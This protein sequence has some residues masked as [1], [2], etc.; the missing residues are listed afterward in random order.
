MVILFLLKYND[1]QF[2]CKI[3]NKSPRKS[4]KKKENRTKKNIPNDFIKLIKKLGLQVKDARLLYETKIDWDSI[5]SE[6]KIY[7]T[8][9]GCDY[10]TQIDSEELTDH[11]MNVH[12]C[13]KYE[14]SDPDCSYIGHS[15]VN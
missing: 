3:D 15:K 4:C 6:N 12:N 8:E 14:C 13:G 5:Y 1:F 10:F 2:E 9:P 7:C 11:M